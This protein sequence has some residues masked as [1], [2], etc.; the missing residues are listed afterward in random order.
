MKKILIFFSLF[1]S[2]ISL[3][4]QEF[5]ITWQ[6]CFGGKYHDYATDIIATCGGYLLIGTTNSTDGDI[7][8]NHG[9]DD[10]WLI[11]ID[12]IGNLIWEKCLGGSKGDIGQRILATSDGNYFV[13]ATAYSSDGTI[14]NDP[15]PNSID[16]WIIKINSEGEIIWDKIV[17]SSK[18]NYLSSGIATNDGG[19]IAIGWSST[20]DGDMTE[21]YGYYDMWMIKLDST[22]SVVWDFTLGGSDFDIGYDIIQT[23]DGGFLVA[24]SAIVEPGGNLECNMHDQADAVLVKL[25]SARNIEWQRCY[26][27]SDYDGATRVGEVNDG[28]LFSGY[29]SS[30]D[31]DV[32]GFHGDIDIW[33]VK[34]DY[35]G[36]I[37]WQKCLGGSGNEFAKIVFPTNDQGF[38]IIGNTES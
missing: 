29:T 21:W 33:V 3:Y 38:M 14:S 5:E 23:S 16:F 7:S 34:V 13:L 26:G 25:D 15:Y 2:I 8:F 31:G 20:N 19:V 24:G 37:I 6:N 22:G 28:Y 30:F 32:S 17:G 9:A 35:I 10:L 4:S 11:K 1:L 12:T 36:N 27:G 18:L